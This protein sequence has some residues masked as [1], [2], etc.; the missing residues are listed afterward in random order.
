MEEEDSDEGHDSR[1]DVEVLDDFGVN[2]G[3]TIVAPGDFANA[4]GCVDK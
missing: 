4:D 3:L 1:N 2:R